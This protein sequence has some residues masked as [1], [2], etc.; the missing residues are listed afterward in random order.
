M[1]ATVVSPGSAPVLFIKGP[2]SA[3]AGSNF[4]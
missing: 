4:R 3:L 1:V 2:L